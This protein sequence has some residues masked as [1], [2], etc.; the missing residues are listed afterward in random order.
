MNCGPRPMRRFV[1]ETFGRLLVLAEGPR[2]GRLR[3]LRVQCSCGSPERFVHAA[4]LTRRTRPTRDC[5]CRKSAVTAA[6]NTTHGS[7]HSYLYATYLKMRSRCYN[8]GDPAYARYGGR[9]ILVSD[10]WN[11]SV[12]TFLSDM[13]ARPPGTSLDRVN[14]EL[15]YS[16][17]NC[18][19]ATHAQQGQ[20]TRRAKLSLWTA[21]VFRV[22]NEMGLPYSFLARCSGT[23][24]SAIA[25]AVTSRTWK[26][27]DP[28]GAQR[29]AV[30]MWS[31]LAV[32]VVAADKIEGKERGQ[33]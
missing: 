31:A 2:R 19:W 26:E 9:G 22:G 11:A 27:T 6:R 14:N 20:N 30:A 4:S 13:G 8:R 24:K 15:G 3:T 18:R 33:A 23:T 28:A 5:G 29:T 25:S 10:S 1:G 12:L 16:K 21:R 32:A 17:E 7:S